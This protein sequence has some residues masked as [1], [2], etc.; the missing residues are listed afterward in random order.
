LLEALHLEARR[1]PAEREDPLVIVRPLIEADQRWKEATLRAGWGATTVARLGELVDAALLPGFVAVDDD[2]RIGLLTFAER[3]DGIEV[4]TIEAQ[5]AGRGIGR[6]LMDA[7]YDHAARREAPRLWLITTNDNVRAF[8]FYQRWGMDLSRVIRDGVA[9]SR[10]VK[11]SIP[12]VGSTGITRRHEL[13]FE[14]FVSD[15]ANV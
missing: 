6:A 8:A 1:T 2:E 4:V 13:E 5:L 3:D 15:E 9:A 12:T 14:R 11:P 7:V 10:T